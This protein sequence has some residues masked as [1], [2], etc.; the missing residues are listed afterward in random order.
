MGTA[1][2]APGYSLARGYPPCAAAF[3][4]G[5]PSLA[6]AFTAAPASSAVALTTARL[7]LFVAL[8]IGV[9]HCCPAA[10][11]PTSASA[12]TCTSSV[13]DSY[14]QAAGLAGTR[15]AWSSALASGVD[16]FALCLCHGG[17]QRAAG[18]EL[19]NGRAATMP[20]SRRTF[21]PLINVRLGDQP[22]ADP[23][24]LL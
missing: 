13:L 14:W 16:G 23:M 4:T 3:T 2:P 22:Q 15:P 17:A 5:R 19:C 1:V 12:S 18:V 7:R 6:A 24:L 10:P 9:D 20:T 8:G 21:R 11:G